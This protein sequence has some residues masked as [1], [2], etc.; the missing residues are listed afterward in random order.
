ML[1]A[2]LWAALWP[3]GRRALNY[4]R[5]VTR[6]KAV[7][8]GNLLA[9]VGHG[10]T[11]SCRSLLGASLALAFIQCSYQDCGKHVSFAL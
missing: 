11:T 5:W 9:A 8:A 6:S 2:A 7:L 4:E 3:T 10:H 1:R